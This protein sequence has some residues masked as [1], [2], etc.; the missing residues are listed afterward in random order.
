M[1]TAL[2]SGGELRNVK[3]DDALHKQD[4][5]SRMEHM[6]RDAARR[7]TPRGMYLLG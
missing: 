4:P 7:S 2:V 5:Q 1:L 6:F 3:A